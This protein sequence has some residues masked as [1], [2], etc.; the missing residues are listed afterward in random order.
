[1]IL[2]F[3][4]RYTWHCVFSNWFNDSGVIA[5][6]YNLTAWLMHEIRGCRLYILYNSLDTVAGARSISSGRGCEKW[7]STPWQH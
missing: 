1:M 7:I 2:Q 5:T 6:N 4:V 3:H